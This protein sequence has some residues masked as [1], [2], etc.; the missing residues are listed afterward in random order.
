MPPMETDRPFSGCGHCSRERWAQLQLEARQ[1]RPHLPNCVR[2]QGR[3]S[4]CSEMHKAAVSRSLQVLPT[5][6]LVRGLSGTTKHCAS[7]I[8]CRPSGPSHGSPP[9]ICFHNL[10]NGSQVTVITGDVLKGTCIATYLSSTL[11]V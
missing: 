3:N 1:A 2:N 7:H 9:S 6:N 11:S 4:I 8:H 10:A 5:G